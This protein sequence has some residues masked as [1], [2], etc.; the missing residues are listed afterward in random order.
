MN[1]SRHV[2]RVGAAS[3]AAFVVLAC[4]ACTG[5]ATALDR[6]GGELTPTPMTLTMVAGEDGWFMLPYVEQVADL[7]HGGMQVDLLPSNVTVA[8]FGRST[9]ALV[10]AVRDGEVPLALVPA[11]DLRPLGVTSLDALLAPFV[12]DSFAM[13]AALLQDDS[14]IAPMLH[15]V[16]ELGVEGLGILPGP[17]VHPFGVKGPL[18]SAADFEGTTISASRGEIAE[19]TLALLGAGFIVWEENGARMDNING[20]LLPMSYVTGNGFHA[21]GRSVTADVMM[22][23]RPLVLIANRDAL[24]ALSAEQ[25]AVLTSAVGATVPDLVGDFESDDLESSAVA[26]GV[27][28]T[29]PEAG[30]DGIAGLRAA[31]RPLVEEIG[32]TDIGAKV[33]AR[34]EELRPSTPPQRPLEC[35]PTPASWPTEVS[36]RLDGTYIADTTPDDLRA[37]GVRELDIIEENWGHY[38]LVVKDGRFAYTQKNALAC[39]WGYGAWRMDDD[40]VRNTFEGGG[41]MAPNYALNKPGEDFVYHWTDFAGTLKLT[42]AM[43]V[44]PDDMAFTRVSDVPDVTALQ[45]EC[46]PPMAAFP[47]S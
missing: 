40:L 7:S 38:T 20:S 46:R 18:L 17:L 35:L 42:L 33:F 41:G 12:I 2:M 4:A 28:L 1:T 43:E 45:A 25:R 19:R 6:S 34:V 29:L 44:G 11:R 10:K 31:V 13:E 9:E 32:A 36:T 3:I 24:A 27:G 30:A 21:S 15:D 14:L 26:C 22:W 8:R 5:G 37:Q 39:T 47:D 23:P 16:D